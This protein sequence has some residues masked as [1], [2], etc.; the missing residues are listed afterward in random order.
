MF[1]RSFWRATA[2]R[3]A[4]GA[5][6]GLGLSGVSSDGGPFNLFAW[7]WHIG[8]GYAAGGALGSLVLSVISAPIGP[9][10]SPS[11]VADPAAAHPG[12]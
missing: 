11:V 1:S 5:A 7:D 4:K 10:G 8:L 12:R 2:E 9:V 3:M 6:I